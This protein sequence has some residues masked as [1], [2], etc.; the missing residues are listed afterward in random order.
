MLRPIPLMWATGGMDRLLKFMPQGLRQPA[1]ALLT[2]SGE[3]AR[4]GR[5]AITAFAIRIASAFLAFVSQIL[6]ARWMGAFEFGVFSYGWVWVIVLGSLV[7][8]GFATSVIRFLPEYREQGKWEFFHGFL[9]TGRAIAAGVGVIAAIIA[10]AIINGTSGWLDPVYVLPLSLV[11]ISLP[12][13]GLTD[14]Q[15]GVGRA[16]GWIDLALIP[17]YILRPIFLFAFIG[18][19]YW[20]AR[21]PDAATAALAL[22]GA[23][24]LTALV[25]Y[26]AQKRRFD[27]GVPKA[28]PAYSTRLWV[29]TSL[30]L[31]MIDGFTL[32]ILNLDVLLLEY[33]RIPP[34]QIGIYF[35]ALKT[36]SL[37][38]FVHFSISA[39]AMPRFAALHA[40]GETGEIRA[41]LGKMQKWCFF[42]SALGAAFLLLIGK[43]LLWLFGPDFTAAYPVMFILALGLLARA[44]AGPAQNLLAVSGHQDK[45]A[46][47]LLMTLLIN[48]ALG[49]LL[50]PRFGIEGA[51]IAISAAFAFEALVTILMTRRYFPASARP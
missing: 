27:A 1:E 20:V 35:A 12:A 32:F 40:R 30:P 16:Q 18:I 47:I 28:S 19:F 50:I 8:A 5:G 42:P 4:S 45:A 9:R 51:A 22:V 21:P 31:F 38:A 44:A 43:P 49:L 41:F 46:M 6:L 29:R 25:Q 3:G 23:C 48:G 36:I 13:Y 34:D 17:P 39:V 33:L 7:S 37:I 11:L 10:Y 2:G 15:D 26:L 14:F 24:W